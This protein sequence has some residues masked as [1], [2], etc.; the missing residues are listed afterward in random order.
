M[1]GQ[2][3]LACPGQR[4]VAVAQHCVASVSR[5][6]SPNQRPSDTSSET[7]NSVQYAHIPSKSKPQPKPR[8]V[9]VMARNSPTPTNLES[10][11]LSDSEANDAEDLFASP[12]VHN[13]KTKTAQSPESSQLQSPPL[14]ESEEIT[15]VTHEANL[16]R[17]LTTLRTMNQVVAGVVESLEKARVNLNAVSAT[18]SNAYTLLTTWTRILSQTEHNQRLILSSQWH[19]SSQDIAD[20]EN[21]ELLRRQ[22]KERKEAEIIQRTEARER[23]KEEEERRRVTEGSTINAPRAKGRSRGT[24]QLG[25]A[26]STSYVGVGGHGGVRGTSARKGMGSVPTRGNARGKGRDL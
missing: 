7:S 15:S 16:R 3:G 11:S 18:V 2:G 9:F 17:E 23:E 19:G 13:G 4:W 26:G 14:A 22:E 1:R 25:R 8:L 21:E 10:L 5:R 12:S 20:G 24:G 6:V